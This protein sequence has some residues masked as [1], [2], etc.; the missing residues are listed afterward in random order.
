MSKFWR[1]R[2]ITMDIADYLED[3]DISHLKDILEV[4]I[5]SLKEV[6]E[7]EIVERETKK[8]EAC[9]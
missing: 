3:G 7:K 2:C 5:P 9:H 6:I 1:I 4:D 8:E